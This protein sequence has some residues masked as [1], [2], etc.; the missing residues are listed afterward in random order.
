V[1][2]LD[3]AVVKEERTRQ[4]KRACQPLEIVD[5]VVGMKMMMVWHGVNDNVAGIGRRTDE[6]CPWKAFM[7]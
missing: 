3:A 2:D 7:V 5:N 6:G 1:V 4:T